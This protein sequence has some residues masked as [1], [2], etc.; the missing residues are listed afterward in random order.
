MN[1]YIYTNAEKGMEQHIA[2]STLFFTS[3]N[4]ETILAFYQFEIF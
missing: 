1:M 2:S 3:E 4:K